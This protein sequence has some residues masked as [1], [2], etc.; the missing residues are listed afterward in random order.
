MEFISVSEAAKRWGVSERSVR[1][2]CAQGRIT[3]AF[4]TGKTWNIPTTAE[5]PDRLNKH[6]DM[7]KT[8]LDVLR[9]EK[10]AKLHGGI[11]HRVQIDLTYNSN[12]IEGSRLTH[13]QTRFIFETNTIGMSDGA[14]KVDDVVETANHFKCIDMVIDSAAHVLSEAFIKQL[15]ATL[16]SGTSNS[17]QDWFAVGDYK[18]LPNEVGGMDTAQPEE[19]ASQMKK[20]LSEYNANKEKSFDDLLDFHYRFE[21]IHP[22][23][24]GNGR[25]GRLVLFK[26]CLRN[27]I[28]PFII[29]ED[30]K[31][32][33]YRGLKEWERERG[34]LRDTCLTAQDKCKKYLD[35]F[36]IPYDN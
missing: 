26:E 1:N 29:D 16:K 35:Y 23:Q 10:A 20:L 4:L 17:R 30:T 31:L 18:K 22:F 12:H 27:N 36:R 5:K 6:V 24:D 28:V 33:Y 2:Y 21:R 11:Y 9:A 34:Y 8:L 13:D 7:P 15:H 32:Y 3:G 25:V 19:V 14:V